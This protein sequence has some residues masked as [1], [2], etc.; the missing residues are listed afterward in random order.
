MLRIRAALSSGLLSVMVFAAFA[1]L[2]TVAVLASTTERSSAWR[3]R[4][5]RIDGS[6]E[7][8][9]GQELPVS[10]EHFSLGIMN[11]GDFLYLCLPTKDMSTKA[12][13]GGAGLV[14]WLDPAGGKKRQFGLHF[15][16][17]NPPGAPGT[18]RR[19]AQEPEKGAPPPEGQ[20]QVEGQEAIGVLGP[21][22]KDAQLVP[23]DEAGGIEARVGVHGDLMVYELKV[24]LKRSADDRY[25][26]NIDAGQTVRMEIETAPLRAGTFPP[27]WGIG[28]AM[29]QPWGRGWGITI[30]GTG[31]RVAIIPFDVTMNVRLARGPQ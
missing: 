21:N 16:V 25:A 6:D 17:P 22:G 8:W 23:L 9:Q 12:Q 2:A 31:R 14:V 30:G 11:D 3:D 18:R 5:V 27:G 7:E 20:S 10:R 26:P 24:P 1:A 19:P 28:G 15:P 4:D 13:I 29:V